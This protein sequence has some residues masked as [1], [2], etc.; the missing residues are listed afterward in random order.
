MRTKFLTCL[1][2]LCLL[3]V[4]MPAMAWAEEPAGTQQTGTGAE[5][6][7][8]T[9]GQ[10]QGTLYIEDGSIKISATGYTQGDAGSETTY[11][12]PYVITQRDKGTPS[13]NT[14]EVTG[15]SPQITIR[16]LNIAYTSAEPVGAVNFVPLTITGGEATLTLEGDNKMAGSAT[17]ESGASIA[18][19]A[20]RS[21]LVKGGAKLAIEGTGSLSLEGKGIATGTYH[22]VGLQVEKGASVTIDGGTVTA[23]GQGAAAGIGGG[24]KGTF[25]TVGIGGWP[26][27]LNNYGSADT[28]DKVTI[29]GGN[30]QVNSI[31]TD[32]LTFNGGAIAFTGNAAAQGNPEAF[33]VTDGRIIVSKS[34][35]AFTAK[36]TGLYFKDLKNQKVTVTVD[37]GQ[38]SEKTWSAVTD[39]DGCLTTYLERGEHTVT[40]EENDPVTVYAGYTNGVVDEICTGS[41][42]GTVNWNV[43]EQITIYDLD[44]GAGCDV[45]DLK[46][47]YAPEDGCTA[48]YHNKYNDFTYEL[49][50]ASQNAT[51]VDGTLTLNRA[52]EDYTV[53]VRI[54]NLAD[55]VVATKTV[56]VSLSGQKGFSIGAGP[57]TIDAA[58]IGKV[59][60]T[61]GT[62]AITVDET[63]KVIISGKAS[64]KQIIVNSGS[65][66]MILKDMTLTNQRT[67]PIK[68]SGGKPTLWLEGQNTVKMTNETDGYYHANGIAI[69]IEKG[70]ELTIDSEEATARSVAGVDFDPFENVQ[71]SVIEQNPIA[72]RYAGSLNVEGRSGSIATYMLATGET[73]AINI[74]GG[75]IYGKTNAQKH[76]NLPTFIGNAANG[77]KPTNAE[78]QGVCQINITGGNI[79]VQIDPVGSSYGMGIGGAYSDIKIT[80][81]CIN[82]TGGSSNN[83]NRLIGIG[84]R[85]AKVEIGTQDDVSGEPYI[86]AA[87]SYYD[88]N[89]LNNSAGIAVGGAQ[90]D[91]TIHSGTVESLCGQLGASIGMGFNQQYVPSG[92]IKICG[93]TV[94]AYSYADDS[95]SIGFAIGSRHPADSGTIEITGG[96][97]ETVGHVGDLSE[98]AQITISGAD[99]NFSNSQG[100]IDGSLTVS[101]GASANVAGNAAGNVTVNGGQVGI[102]GTIGGNAATSNGGSLNIG[103]NVEGDLTVDHDSSYGLGGTVL[104]T[105]NSAGTE[106]PLYVA[107]FCSGDDVLCRVV[108]TEKGK[109]IGSQF[110]NTPVLAGYIFEGWNTAYD[111]SGRKVTADTV[112]NGDLTAYAQWKENPDL[113][114]DAAASLLKGNKISIIGSA[115]SAAQCDAVKEAVEEILK[116]SAFI[117][118]NGTVLVSFANDSFRA[119]LTLD[120]TSKTANLT[121]ALVLEAPGDDQGKADYA[122]K[123]VTDTAIRLAAGTSEKA[124]AAAAEKALR[125][126]VTPYQSTNTEVTVVR[127][128]GHVYRVTAKVGSASASRNAMVI[129]EYYSAAPGPGAVPAGQKPTIQ[130]DGHAKVTLSADGTVA[131]IEAD[132][133]YEVADVVLNGV[134]Q[135]RVTTVRGLKTGDKLVVT[136][137]KKSEAATDRERLI[138]GVRATAVKLSYKAGDVGRGWIRI[139]YKKS[140][141]FKVDGYEIFRSA[142][143][144][145]FGSRPYFA[146]KKSNVSGT[147]KNTKNVK[148][149]TRY[150]YK[151][152]G[153]RKI[154]GKKYYT[155]WSNTVMR[156]GK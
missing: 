93:G 121:V 111:G 124:L 52:A 38:S 129:P 120:G 85:N 66:N 36:S 88:G 135:G 1:L 5:E 91:V 55:E 33:N 47:V 21:L 22:A 80:G 89:K 144:G 15:G 50:E 126:M 12:G 35:N 49:T 113:A 151:V 90:T 95:G 79:S 11:N 84:G 9:P 118:K 133:G 142:K 61:Q 42:G 29:N 150:Y 136:T 140:Y 106:K 74:C 99:T 104:G 112:L 114:V 152:R 45:Y 73:A 94:G 108:H 25:G 117:K 59:T 72:K 58:D 122:L 101:D 26:G 13:G 63:E 92:T 81:G 145:K 141:G 31:R 139:R 24:R 71:F 39:Q 56:A 43:P 102:D 62:K 65:P 60:Y 40:Y 87:M 17:K 137:V 156:T 67:N 107:V 130:A 68:I 100:A 30:V 20:G 148:K 78:G 96:T 110:P 83:G 109:A 103:G 132:D 86:Y 153:V 147:Y 116:D 23:R 46:A 97:V 18:N 119:K 76:G 75:N 19:G 51:L 82:V 131:E 143:K 32:S 14:I 57:I 138:K 16:D 4:M 123:D 70:A 64:D 98:N 125:A 127:L 48:K 69:L 44:N 134:S 6:G 37:T 10:T 34:G 149:G 155:Q 53:S 7:T 77:E 3:A 41:H 54:K 128:Y 115:L 154:E 105:T 27:D 28:P 146:T 2:V 8:G